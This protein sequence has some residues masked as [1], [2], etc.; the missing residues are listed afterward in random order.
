MTSDDAELPEHE[1][2]VLVV[3]DDPNLLRLYSR[4]LAADGFRVAHA[5]DPESAIKLLRTG[6]I[7]V[8]VSDLHMAGGTGIELLRASR[9]IDAEIPV[10]LVTAAPEVQSAAAA[11]EHGAFR[12]LLK[13]VDRD[14]LLAHVQKAQ[15]VRKLA[16]LHRVAGEYLATHVPNEARAS[17]EASF[18]RAMSTLWMAY[19]PIVRSSAQHVVAYE[20][21]LRCREP[22][23]PHP[24]AFLDS[25]RRMGATGKLGRAIRAAVAS[26]AS[27]LSSDVA[28]YVNLSA[29]D[30]QDDEIIDP[31][32]PLSAHAGRVVLEITERAP[33]ENVPD[34]R[35]RV[36]KLRELGYRI[37]LDDLGAGYA[38]LNSFALLEPDV[39]KIDMS[40]VRAVDTDATKRKL[41]STMISLCRELEIDVICEGVETTEERRALEALGCDLLQGYLFARPAE[42]FAEPRW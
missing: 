42:G 39:V 8:V 11:V 18:G 14:E 32:A 23:V 37:A 36:A 24:G 3:D 26:S 35:G 1:T 38:S 13:P 31:S 41:I 5:S 6:T 28:L 33:L 30:L 20:A 25:A 29:G 27:S 16:L 7:D 15:H 21:L 10:I 2:T 12:Y 4:Y 34:L 19:Q 40:L 17:L 9:G 22:A